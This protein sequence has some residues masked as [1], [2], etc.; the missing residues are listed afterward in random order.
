MKLTTVREL[1]KNT[2]LYIDKEVEIGGWIRN[3]RDSKTFGFLVINDGT[4]FQ[5][6]QVVYGDKLN[7]F[8]E[9]C[10]LNVGASVI[11]KGILVATPKAKQPFEIQ[12]S[13]VTVEGPSTP[14]YPLQ[15]KRHPFETENKYISGG[16]QSAFSDRICNPQVLS[17]E[18]FCICTHTAHY[19]Q[20]LR[21]RRRDVSG[22]N[23]G[24]KQCA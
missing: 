6:L 13:E 20:R 7:N 10:K 2:E 18:R 16:I 5:T 23:V 24:F 3:V 11:V 19:R 22:D 15:P 14:D 8:D 4:Y 9:I 21:R 12:A 1:Y 17:G